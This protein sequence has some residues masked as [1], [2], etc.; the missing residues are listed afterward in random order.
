MP[1]QRR[2]PG[3]RRWTQ[4]R[5]QTGQRP[6][7][8]CRPRCRPRCLQA[9]VQGC[10]EEWRVSG[11]P[12]WGD[13]WTRQLNAGGHASLPLATPALAQ[14]HSTKTLIFLNQARFPSSSPAGR[15][16]PRPVKPPPA[17]CSPPPILAPHCQRRAPPP[18]TGD[19]CGVAWV[20]LRDVLLYLAHQVSTHIGGL[21]VDA[22]R[23]AAKQRDGGAA[24]AIAGDGLQ[25]GAAGG[26][27][28]GDRGA[29]GL[30]EFVCEGME[31][32]QGA[33]EPGSGQQW[34]QLAVM[35]ASCNR[36]AT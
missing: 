29:G 26:G 34:S 1:H 7:R 35:A 2:R 8:R 25:G 28:G 21:G 23:H 3:R 17:S 16:N 11:G 33:G 15:S 13:N 30:C 18:L 4:R 9:R 12:W 22:A 10:R 14:L 5:T 19:D 32:S 20:I 27:V 31:A 24:Q 6:C 36:E